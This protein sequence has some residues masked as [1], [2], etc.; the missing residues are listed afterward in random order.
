LANIEIS[1]ISLGAETASLC[2]IENFK[3][4]KEYGIIKSL[5]D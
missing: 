1:A 2:E 4:T 3:Q 5:K